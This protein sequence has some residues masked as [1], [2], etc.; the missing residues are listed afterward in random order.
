MIAQLNSDTA[1]GQLSAMMG[2][3]TYTRYLTENIR[4]FSRIITS[5]SV[6][7]SRKN[8]TMARK[9]ARCRGTD[10]PTV[11]GAAELAQQ[12][13]G[14]EPPKARISKS[15][16]RFVLRYQEV[17]KH[18]LTLYFNLTPPPSTPPFP[19]LCLLQLPI[20]TSNWRTI[21]SWMLLGKSRH[22]A[23][24]GSPKSASPPPLGAIYPPSQPLLT[25]K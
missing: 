9:T 6:T 18:P 19:D 5:R 15:A 20:I 14:Y 7:G 17:E 4:R 23:A 8:S 10:I 11:T 12:R 25:C 21:F 16:G 13:R 1:A 22:Q 24:L 2:A 3:V